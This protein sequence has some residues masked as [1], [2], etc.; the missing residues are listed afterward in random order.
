MLSENKESRFTNEPKQSQRSLCESSL[1]QR[2][3]RGSTACPSGEAAHIE[4]HPAVC[5]PAEFR[6][7]WPLALGCVRIYPY[8]PCERY[9]HPGTGCCQF[10]RSAFLLPIIVICGCLVISLAGFVVLAAVELFQGGL[11]LRTSI[12]FVL[13]ALRG[14]GHDDL[15]RASLLRAFCRTLRRS[16]GEIGSGGLR[17]SAGD[18]A[19]TRDRS[20]R[21]GDSDARRTLEGVL[22]QLPKR[23]R[24]GNGPG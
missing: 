21:S 16:I 4:R 22:R 24:Y 7:F 20:A 8:R 6:A 15:P 17:P 3:S 1:R 14:H 10:G 5:P 19:A 18:G 13:V 11:T 12:V 9:P 2:L 23:A